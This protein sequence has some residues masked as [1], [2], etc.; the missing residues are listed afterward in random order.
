V[1][2]EDREKQL[3]AYPELTGRRYDGA[4]DRVLEAVKKVAK[5][6]GIRITRAEGDTRADARSRGQA[7]SRRRS[8]AR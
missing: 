7:A 4:I 2:P 8:P 5:L 6:N 3:E 1:T